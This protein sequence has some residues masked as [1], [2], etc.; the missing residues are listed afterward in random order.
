[1]SSIVFRTKKMLR[2]SLLHVTARSCIEYEGVR[3]PPHRLRFCGQE[4]RDDQFYLKSG[5]SEVDRLVD[6]CG[7]Q[8]SSSVLD[9]GCGPGRLAIALQQRFPNLRSYLGVDVHSAS[10]QWCQ[11]FLTTSPQ[12]RFLQLGMRNDRYNPEGSKHHP[13]T[14]PRSVFPAGAADVINLFS[15]FS[16]LPLEHVEFYLNEFADLLA[17]GG[18]IFLTAFLNPEASRNF[19]ENPP[20]RGKTWSGPLHCVELGQ[21]WFEDRARQAGLNVTFGPL[22]KEVDGQTAVYLS[23]SSESSAKVVQDSSS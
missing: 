16:H 5:L 18:R 12:F 14:I 11:R 4:F 9:V 17:P 2:N 1:M 6:H 23:H 7:L 22:H 15:V 20:A 21:Q 10:I 19:A 13:S 8:E 3:L